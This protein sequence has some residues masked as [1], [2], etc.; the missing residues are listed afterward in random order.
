MF[1]NTAE[2]VNRRLKYCGELMQMH[3]RSERN[4]EAL[5]DYKALTKLNKKKDILR[6]L[7]TGISVNQADSVLV[8]ESSAIAHFNDL[9][10]QYNLQPDATKKMKILH[11]MKSFITAIYY[12]VIDDETARQA[13]FFMQEQRHNLSKIIDENEENIIKMCEM[14]QENSKVKGIFNVEQGKELVEK[15]SQLQEGY[16]SEWGRIS[17]EIILPQY[18]EI[19]DKIN[20][21]QKEY[22]A[23]I[24]DIEDT[25]R[26]EEIRAEYELKISTLRTDH[27]KYKLALIAQ[28]EQKYLPQ[29]GDIENQMDEMAQKVREAVIAQSTVTQDD[30]KKWVSEKVKITEAVRN[31]CKKHKITIEEFS[32]SLQDFFIITNGRLGNIRIDTKNHNRAY[33]SNIQEHNIEGSIM[34]DNDFSM[35]VLWHELAH[36]IESDDGIRALAQS[37]IRSRSVDGLKVHKLRDLTG[38]NNYGSSEIAY[39]T[40]MFNHYAARIYK[41]GDT[42]LFSMSVEVFQNNQKLFK[43]LLD[44]HKT[45]EFTTAVIMRDK[46]RADQLNKELRDTLV[47]TNMDA[48]NSEYQFIQKQVKDLAHLVKFIPATFSM[49]DLPQSDAQVFIEQMKAK[50]FGELELPD[51]TKFYLLISPKVKYN[52]FSGRAMKGVFALIVNDLKTVIDQEVRNNFVSQHGYVKRSNTYSIQ[53]QDIERIKALVM[54]MHVSGYMPSISDTKG[55]FGEGYLIPKFLNHVQSKFKGVDKG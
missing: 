17:S 48:V 1:E 43:T 35:A 22:R 3:N 23:E 14:L 55:E 11:E 28:H 49:S 19:L 21:L 39:K 42:E 38:N 18:R 2:A 34:L 12:N 5:K 24:K 50:P 10:D 8:S 20:K 44:D 9:M 4:Q 15:K 52:G 6:N 36:H 31:K 26:K 53:T 40:D 46:S 45:I 47:N 32:Q 7:I 25:E 27:G 30:A 51:G 13:N 29:I 16:K 41:Q 54:V 33:A 37:Y